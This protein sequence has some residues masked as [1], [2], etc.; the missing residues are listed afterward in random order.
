MRTQSGF[1]I[2]RRLLLELKP[3]VPVMFITITFGVIGFLAAISIA[4][5]A[6]IALGTVIEGMTLVS[7]ET[8]VI[9]MIVSAVFRGLLRYVEQL[10]GHYI[11]FKILYL[12]RDKVFTKLRTLA[13][14]K[15]EGKDKGN[16]ISLITSDIELL[17]VFYA[18]TI[19][20]IMIAIITNTIIAAI[21]FTIHPTFGILAF[22]FFIL[23]GLVIPI[24]SSRHAKNHGAAYR[25]QFGESNTYVLESL[26]GLKELLLFNGGRARQDALNEQSDELNAQLQKIKQHEGLIAGLTDVIISLSIISFVGI[27]LY[28]YVMN[29]LSLTLTLVAIVM[30]ASS[31]G[32]VVALSNLA[33]NL[34][35]TFACAQRLFDLLDEE[36]QITEIAGERELNIT[37]VEFENVNFAYPNSKQLILE[38]ASLS[39]KKG[40]RVAIV[41]ESGVGKSTF[42]KLLMRTFDPQHGTVSLNKQAVHEIPTKTL[43]QI[44]TLMSQETHLFNTSIKENLLLGKADANDEELM[45]ACQKASIHE[46]IVSLPQG[47]DTRVGELGGMLS[48]GEKQRLGLARAFLHDGDLL[49]LDE[50][51]SNLDALNEAE[52]LQSLKHYTKDKTVVL[53]SHRKSTTAIATKTYTLADKKLS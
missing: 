2:M 26:R 16:L 45:V 6:A 12:L 44:Q 18:H 1:Q 29:Q 21:L 13:P 33:N 48:S 46:F 11:A 30:I 4:T 7:F 36:A 14:A 28:L 19:A 47:Y 51:T 20:P 39:L 23:I 22:I 42:V 50:P 25:E 35:H 34:L 31:F 5:F 43:R 10:S 38:Q 9:I 24:A 40:D 37:D 32:P 3:L 41:G 53:I 17:E 49:I 15:L 52:I 27:G 8:A